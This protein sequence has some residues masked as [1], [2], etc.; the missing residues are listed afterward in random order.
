MTTGIIHK[1]LNSPS[2]KTDC[3][4]FDDSISLKALIEAVIFAAPKPISVS[5]LS[6]VLT[7]EDFEASPNIIES[8]IQQL[9]S[10]YLARNAGFRLEYD[11]GAGYQFR[12]A[13]GA[14]KIME[15]MFASSQRSVSRASLET[16]SIIAYNQPCTR[17][18]IEQIRG[19]DVGSI[20]ASLLEKEFVTCVGRKAVPGRPMLFGTTNEFLRCFGI[21]SLDKLPPLSD[22]AKQSNL[23][24]PHTSVFD[25]P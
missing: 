12:T 25:E 14:A 19:V 7:D 1:Y 22:F 9:A 24:V 3:L 15:K 8:I 20:I 6:E 18:E 16:L 10:E 23:V 21:Q 11:E 13:A 5:N 2:D 4:F 17:A